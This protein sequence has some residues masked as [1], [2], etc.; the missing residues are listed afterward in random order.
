[1]RENPMPGYREEPGVDLVSA[2]ETFV[3]LRLDIA[4]GWAGVPVFVRTGKR[5]PQRLST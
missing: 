4:T 1:M 5:L 3:A 2:V